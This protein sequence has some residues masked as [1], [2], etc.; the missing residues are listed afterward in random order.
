M[1]AEKFDEI[2][3]SIIEPISKNICKDVDFFS[4]RKNAKKNVF[5]HYINIKETV[6]KHYMSNK[7][8][9]IDRHKIA[10]CLMKAILEVYPL[11]LSIMHVIKLWHSKKHLE[12]K[13]IYANETLA[14][15]SGLSIL[16]NFKDYD[17][18]GHN[19]TARVSIKI[20]KTYNESNYLLNTY[21]DL[22]F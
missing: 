7:Q 13:Y 18:N 4:I 17:I 22:Y 2:W 20:P 11:R 16:E 21:I 5:R 12:E 8:Q 10:A 3:F 15:Y 1:T 6:K 9:N 14:F 19:S